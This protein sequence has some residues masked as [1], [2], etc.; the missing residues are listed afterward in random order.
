VVNQ[1]IRANIRAALARANNLHVAEPAKPSALLENVRCIVDSLKAGEKTLT[2]KE[3][4]TRHDLSLSTVYREFKGKLGCFQW[5]G[6]W[7][8]TETL[9]TQWL[10]EC[11]M[12]A[13]S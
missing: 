12:K 11:V 6:K 3:I 7:V 2:M 13:A 8:A 4:A 5:R 1:R 10:T 9:Y